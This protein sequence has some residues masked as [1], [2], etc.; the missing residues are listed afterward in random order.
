MAIA[1]LC[2]GCQSLFRLPDELA[3]THVRCQ[4]CQRMLTVPGVIAAPPKVAPPKAPP[5]PE[6]MPE[7]PTVTM[8]PAPAP[9]MPPPLPASPTVGP[10]S[11]GVPGVVLVEV[12]VKP[13][14]PPMP[15]P[16]EP[17]RAQSEAPAP[18]PGPTMTLAG[19]DRPRRSTNRPRRPSSALAGLV[20]AAMALLFVGLGGVSLAVW[21]YTEIQSAPPRPNFVN[22]GP[23]FQFKQGPMIQQGPIPPGG[24]VV[25]NPAFPQ[26]DKP[27][28]GAQGTQQAFH[29]GPNAPKKLDD[30]L[31][32][33]LTLQNG[34]LVT[35]QT[36]NPNDL[37]DPVLRWPGGLPL[38]CKPFLIELEQ[39]KRYV[40]DY[41]RAAFNAEF[42][43][44]LRIESLAGERLVEHDD[45]QQI[46][47]NNLHDM[48]SRI[49]FHPPKTAT[50]R[51]VCTVFK[52]PLAAGH[53]FTLTIRERP[54]TPGIGNVVPPQPGKGVNPFEVTPVTE[55]DLQA[56]I[57]KLR[58]VEP[59][60][61]ADLCWSADG[62]A[63]YALYNDGLLLKVGVD[64][65]TE[66]R[67]L[68][69]G[70][71]PGGLAMSSQGLVVT[72]PRVAVQV[73]KAPNL[74]A[75]KFPGAQMVPGFNGPV[76]AG[77]NEVWL[78]DPDSLTVKNRF[79][80]FLR[81]GDAAVVSAPSLDY[82]FVVSTG[83]TPSYP[84]GHGV[85]VID[86][87]GKR[88]SRFFDLPNAAL[89]VSPR[90]DYLF[91]MDN[92][93]L[94]SFAINKETGELEK[95]QTSHPYLRNGNNNY[96]V[97]VSADGKHVAVSGANA[98]KVLQAENPKRGASAVP[99]Y[100]VENLTKPVLTIDVD[101]PAR[102]VGFD[103]IRADR[104]LT[105]TSD[106]PLALFDGTGQRRGAYRLPEVGNEQQSLQFLVHPDGNKALIRFQ[107]RL[108]FANFKPDVAP[109]VVRN[110]PTLPVP[111]PIKDG[112][113]IAGEA[114]KQVDVTYRELQLANLGDI[115]PC[116]DAEG[117][118]L[119]HLD[120]EGTLTRIRAD[121]FI[122]T[123]RLILGRPA[124]AMAL[125]SQGLL[126]A[127]RDQ[128]EVW[129]I[130]PQTL[131]V[132]RAIATPS[133]ARYL[134]CHPQQARAVAVGTE[135]MLLDVAQ[136]KLLARGLDK[137]EDAGLPF[138][139]PALT[140]DG[141]YLL[142]AHSSAAAGKVLRVK[143][144][145]DRLIVAES[146]NIA[147]K[148]I[149]AFCVTADSRHVAWYT[150]GGK[151]KQQPAEFYAID[152]WKAPAFVLPAQVRALA[153]ADDGS[154]YAQT[155]EFDLLRYPQP[156]AKDAAFVSLRWASQGRIGIRDIAAQ[157]R[158]AGA[159]LASTGARVL[160]GERNAK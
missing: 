24:P 118:A 95:K 28:N 14:P 6:P 92:E 108:C 51:I 75:M 136:G 142:L 143:V 121:D 107:D 120:S 8:P 105:Q 58:K 89:A 80:A 4:K 109:A 101:V 82:A 113:S 158:H 48:N 148:G 156:A 73:P 53:Q 103:T 81:A 106:G 26:E 64:G 124:A 157:P 127:M 98:P 35:Q 79:G 123:D 40:I 151:G 155:A 147:G 67:R 15:Q 33:K 130:Q 116:W 115:D 17:A 99:V 23:Q 159:F 96:R 59:R 50:Y 86:V 110:D 135:V 37:R 139:D 74:P 43:P 78:I 153:A 39:G 19:R 55:K 104:V 61:I 69:L 72:L 9:M 111:T 149:H 18:R 128:P 76:P 138:H 144:E 21:G 125:S 66:Q 94:T 102:A 70:R 160:Y 87:T 57:L 150:P 71:V 30:K 52:F 68:A 46:Q 20:L 100:V 32:I 129:V 49:E 117:K 90:G 31:A 45:V 119:F 2:P 34:Q 16:T 133:P 41:Q 12:P 42:D 62:K 7:A 65:F 25:V 1:T 27:A 131:R 56:S 85:L 146:R 141:K 29:P 145:A 63:F 13:V 60:P 3:G 10:P 47:N 137:H 84:P 11:D 5:R 22:V 122:S 134:A 126:V 83:E 93:V 91:T 140:P 152:D 114:K 36:L 154:V 112:E 54:I 97:D 77:S 132:I 38:P 88:A 44:Y